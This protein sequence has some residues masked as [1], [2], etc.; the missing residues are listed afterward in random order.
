MVK[1]IV[2]ARSGNEQ[3]F[4]TCKDTIE[5]LRIAGQLHRIEL[6]SHTYTQIR[7]RG[8]PVPKKL[9]K[10]MTSMFLEGA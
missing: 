5:A 8:S 2:T 1:N 6:K 9:Y 4:I 7:L 3:I 10:D